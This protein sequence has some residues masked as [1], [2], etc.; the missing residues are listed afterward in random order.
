MKWYQDHEGNTSSMRIAVMLTTITGCATV[1]AGVVA[2]FLRIP[3]A[4]AA[5]GAGAGMTGLGEVA[6]AWQARVGR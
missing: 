6:K 3:E 4:I 5:I 1:V 2:L